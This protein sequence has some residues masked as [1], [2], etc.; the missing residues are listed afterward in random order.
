MLL[1]VRCE[2]RTGDP[3]S[4]TLEAADAY[5]ATLVTT[6]GGESDIEVALAKK[7]EMVSLEPGRYY[8][9]A[10][11]DNPDNTLAHER[12]SDGDAPVWH[13]AQGVRFL[14]SMF[15]PPLPPATDWEWAETF[16]CV[17]FG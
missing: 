11:F 2:Y 7:D 15:T 12:S 6:P 14:D 9:P 5:G 1:P 3:S 10:E 16:H 17:L 8:V 13:C 4:A